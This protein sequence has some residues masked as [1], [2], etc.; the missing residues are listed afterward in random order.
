MRTVREMGVE[1]GGRGHLD[2]SHVANELGGCAALLTQH[3]GAEEG[4]GGLRLCQHPALRRNPLGAGLESEQ[5]NGQRQSVTQ[6]LISGRSG[7]GVLG[8]SR[9]DMGSVSGSKQLTT[10]LAHRFGL[11][12]ALAGGLRHGLWCGIGC[13]IGRASRLAA[14]AGSVWT[15]GTAG[16]ADWV[17]GRLACGLGCGLACGL[18]RGLWRGL[19]G[20]L[21]C[22]LGRRLACGL[23]RRFAGGVGKAADERGVF[24]TARG[25]AEQRQVLR[26]GGEGRGADGT[27][28]E[29]PVLVVG[30]HAE[31]LAEVAACAQRQARDAAAAAA[32][33]F[34]VV[35]LADDLRFM[36]RKLMP[37][38]AAC[39]SNQKDMRQ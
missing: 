12:G 37:V 22:G 5:R 32:A 38:R 10:E 39:H 4:C 36:P 8:P 28:A 13:G 25:A 30:E 35:M 6:L 18:G 17:A 7:E 24:L 2:R 23:G 3:A 26:L 1:V 11:A 33:Y 19:G 9:G 27:V 34:D 31:V 16:I 21:V 14:A 29:L 15:A 20:G